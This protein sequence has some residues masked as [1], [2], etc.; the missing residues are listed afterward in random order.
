M[1]ITLQLKNVLIVYLSV[2]SLTLVGSALQP[3]DCLAYPCCQSGI[4]SYYLMA[5]RHS[6]VCVPHVFNHSL[7]NGH[8]DSFQALNIVNSA[9]VNS[10]VQLSSQNIIC[11]LIDS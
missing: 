7:V 9:V 2:S 8:F 1:V 10:E 6:V 5:R 4:I 3:V 11:V